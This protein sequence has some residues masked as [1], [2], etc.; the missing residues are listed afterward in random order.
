MSPGNTLVGYVPS[1]PSECTPVCLPLTGLCTNGM[2][3]CFYVQAKEC[4][5]C[6]TCT[7]LI[8][9]CVWTIF[10]VILQNHSD[11]PYFVFMSCFRVKLFCRCITVWKYATT[12]EVPV[13]GCRHL[14]QVC[15]EVD[16]QRTSFICSTIYS[17][18]NF[19]TIHTRAAGLL[20]W[21]PQIHWGL[22]NVHRYTAW[23]YLV[24]M[25]SSNKSPD[26]TVV[27]SCNKVGN[28]STCIKLYK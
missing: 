15:S 10:R 26:C 17:A 23:W 18:D 11:I 12:V 3:A 19:R 14:A 22:N 13:D 9:A 27:G 20:A 21:F 5:R 24:H 1:S 8:E 4:R 2:S 28:A 25:I 7:K 6:L 16:H